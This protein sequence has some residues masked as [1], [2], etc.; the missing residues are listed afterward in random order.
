MKRTYWLAE[1]NHDK[2][3]TFRAVRK[4]TCEV[5]GEFTNGT[6]IW[7]DETGE[8]YYCFRLLGVYY[9]THV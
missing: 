2:Y 7:Q 8:Q 6:K 9:F 5:V 1:P 3:N 4:I